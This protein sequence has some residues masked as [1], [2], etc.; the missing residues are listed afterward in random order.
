MFSSNLARKQ[1]V[2]VGLSTGQLSNIAFIELLFYEIWQTEQIIVKYL[3]QQYK[4]LR[5]KIKL[6]IAQSFPP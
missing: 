5:V 2:W 3:A 1:I 4:A 6:A